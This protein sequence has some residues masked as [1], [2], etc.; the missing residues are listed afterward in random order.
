M[1][2]LGGVFG[3][4]LMGTYLS[5]QTLPNLNNYELIWSD[6]F[7]QDGAPNSENWRYEH[8]FVRNNELQ[9]Y[10]A[11]NAY[12]KNGLLV[13]EARKESNL[14]NPNY[15]SDSKEWRKNREYIDYTS[16]CLITAGKQEWKAGGY[17]EV[18][19]RINTASGSWPAI[20][21][22]GNEK[23]WPDNGEID[24]MEF[25]RINNEPHILANAAWGTSKRYTAAWDSE[26][27]LFKSFL[28]KDPNWASK[29]HV[30]AMDWNDRSMN[31][32]LDGELLNEIDLS[33]IKNAD[34]TNPFTSEQE[35]YF[36]L[37]LAVGSNG[38]VPEE[39]AFPL[40]YEVDYVRVYE[41]K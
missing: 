22:L 4:C 23:E 8:G 3:F 11:E 32:Y 17:Y 36:L 18:R 12:C 28:E 14:K 25:Y 10:Q 2:M 19:A 34:G 16:S 20:W 7:N 40:K 38:G 13:I 6:E 5:A 35:F 31:I 33:K 37:N 41:M 39:S 9:W 24:I 30:W 15:V 26:K 29:F 27:I 21:L 1:V